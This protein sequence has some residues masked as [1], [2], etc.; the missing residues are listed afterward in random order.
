MQWSQHNSSIQTVP[1]YNHVGRR[2]FSWYGGRWNHSKWFLWSWT[3]QTRKDWGECHLSMKGWMMEP[4]DDL[5]MRHLAFI[6]VDIPPCCFDAPFLCKNSSRFYWLLPSLEF[7]RDRSTVST[8]F[9]RDKFQTE[10]ELGL[11]RLLALDILN[12]RGAQTSSRASKFKKNGRK[13]KMS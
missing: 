5:V 11:L 1:V 9:L 3:F 8:R 6:V 12:G 10:M 4:C 13:Q 2:R 7:Q